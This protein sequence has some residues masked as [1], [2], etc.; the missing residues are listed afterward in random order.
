MEVLSNAIFWVQSHLTITQECAR[1]VLIFFYGLALLRL[2]G[3]RVFGHWSAMDVVVSVIVGS[4]L[5]RAMTGSAPLLGTM[6]AAAVMVI[7]HVTLSA[8]IARSEMLSR[9]VEGSSVSLAQNGTL[10]EAARKSHMISRSDLVEALRLQGVDGLRGMD[11]VKAVELE[12]SEAEDSE[13]GEGDDPG[14]K[15]KRKRRESFPDDEP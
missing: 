4:A 13:E 12:P 6:A 8:A 9:L 3:R 7:R 10:D 1:A 5:A 2:C 14:E 11:N 15:R